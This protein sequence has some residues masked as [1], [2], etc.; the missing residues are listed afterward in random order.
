MAD[1]QSLPGH[2]LDWATFNMLL[3]H[4][5]AAQQ[6]AVPAVPPASGAHYSQPSTVAGQSENHQ[7]QHLA[8]KSPPPR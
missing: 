4:F 6:G 7:R 8:G 1:A 3:P 2:R 5:A